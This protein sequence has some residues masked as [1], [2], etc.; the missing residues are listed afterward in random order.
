MK[1]TISEM[2]M[3]AVLVW[4]VPWFL[5][6]VVISA[7]PQEVAPQNTEPSET[8]RP[9]QRISVKLG[10]EITEMKL[11]DYLTAVLLAELPGS[12]HMEAKMAQAV[13][14]RTYAL[15][16]V[17]ETDKH[18]GAVCGDSSCCQGYRSPADYINSGGIQ[19]VVDQA[20][21]AVQQTEG[22][23]LTYKGSLIDATY[24]AC[25]GGY[26]EPAV[27][28]WGTEVPYLQA[29]P[30]P[31]EEN[32]AHYT[33]TVTMTPSEFA[34]ALER[35][36]TGN[37]GGWFGPV[38]YT[39]GGGVAWMTIGGVRYSGKD[40]RTMLNLRSTAFT[41]TATDTRI[42]IITRGYGH[43]VGMSQYGAQAM[44]LEGSAWR[45]ILVHYY[46][47]TEIMQVLEN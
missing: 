47:G 39:Q 7:K 40:L 32:A 9:E 30:S 37:P 20:R 42:Q 1:R 14:A 44:A 34:R 23:V 25:S 18:H 8:S 38:T 2:L 36:L 15:R 11:E 45:Q 16:T 21:M 6:S 5:V 19:A 43:R 27:A 28:V 10:D 26:T 46:P 33:D 35:E 4:L 3:A 22:L 41:V 17:A 12:F 31:G 24:F 13:V 29:V